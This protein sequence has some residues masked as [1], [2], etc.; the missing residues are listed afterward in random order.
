V[1]LE[2]YNEMLRAMKTNEAYR[3]WLD[4]SPADPAVAHELIEKYRCPGRGRTEK[5]VITELMTST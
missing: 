2:I 5:T 1:I 3:R 4:P